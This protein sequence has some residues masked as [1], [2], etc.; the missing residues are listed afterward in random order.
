MSALNTLT[1]TYLLPMIV[2]TVLRSNVLAVRVLSDVRQDN[3]RGEK[4]R[5]SIKVTK[6]TNTVSFSGMQVLPSQ[7]VNTRQYIEF[8]AKFVQIDVTVAF[9]DIV[10][11]AT[12]DE[13]VLALATAEATSSAE[14]M[15]DSVGSMFYLDGT[16][17]GS[18]DFNGLGNIV[19]DSGTYG[20]L[21]RSTY[22]TI[23]AT[24]T[25]SGGTLTLQKMAT[26]YNNI[27]D[28]TIVPNMGLSDKTVFSLYEQLIEPKNRLY[29][30]MS[31]T[32]KPLS[33]TAGFTALDYK[34]FGITPDQK[35]SENAS[36]TLFFLNDNFLFFTAVPSSGATSQLGGVS[37]VQY[38]EKD[39]QGNDYTNIKGLGFY[40]GGW[41]R[42]ANQLGFTGRV[43]LG[44]EFWSSN[45]RRNGKLTGIS[46]V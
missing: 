10:V 44:G 42:P 32:K 1:N 39:F 26:L 4:I 2:D 3:W 22:T 17:N 5:K 9:T 14:D 24:N 13:K 25:A 33:G 27:S 11:N 45:P 31:E 35:A 20:G 40:W 38:K 36:Q 34:G 15:A 43:I 28:G 46:T 6:N 23:Q 8:P 37:P 29:I 12:D 19:S 7:A 18:L 30:T 41:V 21:S 16:G